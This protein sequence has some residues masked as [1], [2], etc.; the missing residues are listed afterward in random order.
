MKAT[1]EHNRRLIAAE[2]KESARLAERNPAEIRVVAITKYVD[3]E[4]A[5]TLADLG[6]SDLGEN[7]AAALEAEATR[8]ESELLAS[9]G[10]RLA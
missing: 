1:L 4:V 3:A 8:R 5:M 2:I 9:V 6:Q 10:E 7:R